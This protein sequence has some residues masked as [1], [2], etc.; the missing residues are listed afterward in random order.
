MITDRY[1]LEVHPD[2]LESVLD[3]LNERDVEQ[4]A[5]F[6]FVTEEKK[7]LRMLNEIFFKKQTEA[8]FW[9]NDQ[10]YKTRTL[11]ML[12]VMYDLAK[13]LE[14]PNDIFLYKKYFQKMFG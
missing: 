9:F 2:L 4:H 11:E 8:S 7:L 3:Y 10:K 12:D 1:E 14:Y 13:R 6:S 5:I